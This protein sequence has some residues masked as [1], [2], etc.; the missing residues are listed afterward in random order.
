MTENV[1]DVSLDDTDGDYVGL[2]CVKITAAFLVRGCEGEWGGG[3]KVGATQKDR[4]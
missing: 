1:S 4:L 2:D 3:N